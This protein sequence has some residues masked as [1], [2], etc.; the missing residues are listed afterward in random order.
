MK[1]LFPR[2]VALTLA[3]SL[4]GCAIVSPRLEPEVPVAGSWNES[5][6]ADAV[7]G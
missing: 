4:S 5:A 3:V 2:V 6:P 7:G 1:I